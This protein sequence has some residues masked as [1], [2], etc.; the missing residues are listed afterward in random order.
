[1]KCP[2]CGSKLTEED[3]FCPDCGTKVTRKNIEKKIEEQ[4]RVTQLQKSVVQIQK[5]YGSKIIWGIVIIILII[6][7]FKACGKTAEPEKPI[8]VEPETEQPGYEPKPFESTQP[9]P[10]KE[11]VVDTS[12]ACSQVSAQ[13]TDACWSCG[14]VSCG[15]SATVKNTGSKPIFRFN[16]KTYINP[17][18]K[19]ESKVWDPLDAGA[20]RTYSPW[21]RNTDVRLIE[22]IPIILIDDQ[23]VI[24]ESKVVSYG[25][26]YGDYFPKCAGSY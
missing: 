4:P 25:N 21:A 17:K 19:D 26:A 24:C 8:I 23:E 2:K 6:F 15:L 22:L 11:P 18:E 5:S 9:E 20:E 10:E 7:L 3:L 1:M 14:I 16:T 12:T 13:I